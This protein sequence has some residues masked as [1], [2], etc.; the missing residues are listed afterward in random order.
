[1]QPGR[2]LGGFP[3]L[4]PFR[5]AEWQ[6]FKG[7][8]ELVA[9][10][11]EKLKSS[12]FLSVIGSSGTG[13]SSLVRAGLMRSILAGYLRHDSNI[14]NVAICRPGYDPIKNLCV[15]LAFVKTKSWSQRDARVDLTRIE[16][17]YP[18][19]ANFLNNTNSLRGIIKANEYLQADLPENQKPNLLIIVDQF[20]ELFRFNIDGEFFYQFADYLPSG[21][22]DLCYHH[23][24]LR[25]SWI[26]RTVSGLS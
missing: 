2:M 15:A 21:S 14:W 4:R 11:I 3:G 23:H 5:T 25:I 13:K 26:L 18:N 8:E 24:A 22:I 9:E 12:R 1:M 20:E 10:L 16:G 17:E 7:R 19:M 6:L